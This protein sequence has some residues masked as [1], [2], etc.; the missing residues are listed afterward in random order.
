ML[1]VCVRVAPAVQG[2]ELALL[3]GWA[4]QGRFLLLIPLCAPGLERG[5][6]LRSVVGCCWVH[7]LSCK[8]QF[9]KTDAAPPPPKTLRH[10]RGRADVAW[11]DRKLKQRHHG[12]C[13]VWLGASVNHAVHLPFAIQPFIGLRVCLRALAM[14]LLS[15][16][17][18]IHG[19]L[20]VICVSRLSGCEHRA[21]I[22][23]RVR[24]ICTACY[25]RSAFI[26]ARVYGEFEA[27]PC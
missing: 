8:G 4:H 12:S 18:D 17:C 14:Q 23:A 15:S 6:R 1:R 11:N 13:L 3:A 22:V 19:E 25:M 5:G 9:G 20:L 10:V 26:H 21:D 7:L 16:P 2:L 27:A 24:S